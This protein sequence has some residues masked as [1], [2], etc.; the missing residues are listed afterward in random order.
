MET[1]LISPAGREEIVLGKFL[2]IWIFSG[3]TALLNLLSMGLTTWHFSEQIVAAISAS[4]S[5]DHVAVRLP[6]VA[7]AAVG[8][9]QRLHL[10]RGSLCP[11]LE[12][13]AILSDALVPHRHAADVLDARPG[14][15]LNPF[16]SLVPVTGAA[17]LMQKLMTATSLAQVPWLYLIPVLAPLVLYSYLALRWAIAQFQREE[18]LFREAERLDMRLWLKT[19]VPRKGSDADDGQ[20]FF[21][22]VLMLA[23]AWISLRGRPRIAH[24]RCT[25]ASG[26]WP[27]SRPRPCWRRCCSTP[28]QSKG[29]G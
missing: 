23:F 26:C 18:V 27:S 9:L 13:G 14:A 28:G 17:L 3:G 7:H 10:G 5:A 20:A 6:D 19:A 21:V 11:Q 25:P 24:S 15:E 8:L 1:L 29:C 4:D 22:F 2:T 12:G 16:Y